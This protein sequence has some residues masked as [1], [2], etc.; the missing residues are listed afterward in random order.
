MKQLN[1]LGL[2]L[3]VIGF[4]GC[5]LKLEEIASVAAE[6][7][8]TIVG[9]WATACIAD[10]NDSYIRSFEVKDDTMTIATLRYFDNRY[11]NQAN[12]GATIMQ[13]GPITVSG[14]SSTVAGGKNYEWQIASAVVVPNI[15]SIVTMLNTDSAC[16]SNSWAL[17]Q[18]GFVFGCA[19]GADF[20]MTQVTFNTVHYGVFNIEGAATPNYLQFESKCEI[21]GYEELCPTPADR[22][23]TLGGTTYFKN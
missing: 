11:C 15:V 4:S 20:D 21:A 17:N 12:L 6:P 9:I 7:E 2:G 8:S 22:P 16:G 5:Q 3:L 13:S 23:A 18:P 10:S 14:D 19:I 1:I